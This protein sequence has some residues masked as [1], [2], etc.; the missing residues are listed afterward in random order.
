MSGQILTAGKT[1]KWQD[2]ASSF[3]LLNGLETSS[4]ILAVLVWMGGPSLGR[5]DSSVR[6][7]L[8][9]FVLK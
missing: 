6:L 8:S 4:L 9:G 7:C 2:C 1:A 3:A 5:S